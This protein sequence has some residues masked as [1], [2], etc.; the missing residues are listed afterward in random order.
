M[1]AFRNWYIS[2][3]IPKRASFPTLVELLRDSALQYSCPPAI[4]DAMRGPFLEEYGTN[5]R[6]VLELGIKYADGY[7]ECFDFLEKNMPLVNPQYHIPHL[8]RKYYLVA[9]N[10]SA[11]T[12]RCPR[13][14]SEVYQ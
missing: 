12:R 8:F 10:V 3:V 4:I 7:A 6:P 9:Y 2:M 13:L 5:L 11:P 1:E 14:A